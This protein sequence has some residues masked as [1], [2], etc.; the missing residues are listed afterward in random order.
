MWKRVLLGV[1]L[2]LLILYLLGRKVD[3]AEVLALLA[4]TRLDLLLVALAGAFVSLW[5]KGER[6]SLAIAAGA[7]PRPRKRLFA[8]TVIGTAG[9]LLLPARLGDLARVLVF[10]KHNQVP[11]ARS[12][13]ASWSAQLFDMLA[14]AVILL[15]AGSAFASR[16]V[17]GLVLGGLLALLAAFALVVRRPDWAER[18]E[19]RL[20]P[21]FL[22]AKLAGL[23]ASGR[24]GLH[25]LNHPPTL[26]AIL[27]LTAAVW[28]VETLILI[29]ALRAFGLSLGLGVAALLAAAIGLSFALPLTPGNIGTYQLVCILVLGAAGVERDAAFAF[30]LGY[31]AVSLVVV[32]VCGMILLQREGMDVRALVAERDRLKEV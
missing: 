25:F 30:G 19:K 9:N 11:A 22:H 32:A 17:L 15:V 14:V 21:R 3:A 5:L 7:R 26:A 4:K 31:Q 20:L 2:A 8:A 23:L 12:L 24:Q 16:R 1:F 6:W 13:I 28:V 18:L 29:V 10:R 27:I